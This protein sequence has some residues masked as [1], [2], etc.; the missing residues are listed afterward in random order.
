MLGALASFAAAFLSR[1]VVDLVDGWRR[2]RAAEELGRAKA[3]AEQR[4]RALEATREARRIEEDAAARHRADPT[5]AAFDQ[6]FRRG[7]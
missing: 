5:D 4:G 2:A 3:L 7:D 6:D 1:V